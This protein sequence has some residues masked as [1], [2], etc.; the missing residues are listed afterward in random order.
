MNVE[1]PLP[2]RLFKAACLAVTAGLAAVALL[3]LVL[4]GK[5]MVAD[6]PTN[7]CSSDTCPRGMGRLLIFV[8]L[9]GIA[10]GLLW[11]RIRADTATRRSWPARLLAAVVALAALWPGWSGYE[12]M[13]GPQM[14][15][16]GYQA[17]D[18]PSSVKPVGVWKP[19]GPSG[20]V[21][22]ARTDM[23]VAFNG[24]G[25]TGWRLS[26]PD[27]AAVCALSRSTPSNVGIVAYEG[28][29]PVCGSKIEAVDLA[30]G[31]KLWAKDL[32]PPSVSA[33]VGGT[34]VV[35]ERGSLIGLDLREGVERWRVPVPGE[36]RVMALDGAGDRALYVEQCAS[37]ARITAVDT[38][39]GARSWQTPLPTASPLREAQVLSAGP[40]AVRVA[41]TAARGTDAVLLFDD[42]GRARGSVPSSGPE[43]DLRSQP[44]PVVSGE[45]LITPVKNGKAGGVSAYSLTDGHRVWHAGFGK[46]SVNG[47]AAGPAGEV[48]VV[49]SYRWWKYL[50][51]LDVDS[52][53]REQES[54]VLRDAPLG[55]RFAFYPSSPGYCVFV[56]LDQSGTLPPIFDMNPVMGW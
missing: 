7:K 24:E 30:E 18:R 33:A 46:E 47:L 2:E 8:P 29:R 10:A 19:D 11:S 49:T 12:W 48:G 5:L 20:M 35:A 45:L 28:D 6:M 25:R 1:T 56:N 32:A 16:F 4:F 13:R 44:A 31:R 9:L 21:V 41:E 22:R 50:T 38:R 52:G 17:P 34:A 42:T 51:R 39:T 40:V 54:A 37:A 3:Y 14:D 43:E 23:L 27:R 53:E 26:A 36:C 55:T 15:V